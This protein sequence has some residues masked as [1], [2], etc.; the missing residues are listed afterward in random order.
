MYF[1]HLWNISEK[2]FAK[3]ILGLVKSESIHIFLSNII[4]KNLNDLRNMITNPNWTFQSRLSVPFHESRQIYNHSLETRL[5]AQ[6]PDVSIL[7]KAIFR[8]VTLVWRVKS[9]KFLS[10][11]YSK[12]K[13]IENQVMC[14]SFDFGLTVFSRFCIFGS[15]RKF[16]FSIVFLQGRENE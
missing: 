2:S 7:G 6:S 5:N 12:K 15:F 11:I 16:L 10:T 3:R 4:L 9:L 8:D 14:Q 1:F 13:K